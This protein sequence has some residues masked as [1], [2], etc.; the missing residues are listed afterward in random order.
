MA[1]KGSTTHGAFAASYQGKTLENDSENP[2]MNANANAN[3]TA[4]SNTNSKPKR[5]CLCEADY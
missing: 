2:D 4:T 3:A 5:N 1:Q